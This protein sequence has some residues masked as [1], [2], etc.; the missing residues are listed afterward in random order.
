MK[1]VYLY[2]TLTTMGGADRIIIQK[3]N[4]LAGT[5][6]HKIYIITDSQEGRPVVFPLSPQITHIDT[7]TSFNRQ[8]DL[9]FPLRIFHYGMQMRKYRKAVRTLLSQIKPDI[10]ISTLG[11]DSDFLV[12]LKD[13]SRKIGETHTTRK[14]LRNMQGLLE[15]KGIRRLA[16]LFLKYRIEKT[17]RR[18]DAFIVLNDYEKEAWKEIR[19]AGVIPNSLPFYPAHA[20]DLKPARALCVSRLEQEKGVD[21]LIEVWQL[22]SRKHP[23]WQ[24]DIIG[25]GTQREYLQHLLTEKEM[26][27]CIRL[28]PATQDIGKHYLHSSM[29]LLASRFEGFP[30]VVLEAM[31]Y[32]LPCVCY[33]CPYGPRSIIDNGK[34]GFLVKEGDKEA[35]AD[36]ICRLIEHETLRKDMGENARRDIRKYSQ[37]SVMRQWEN[38]FESVIR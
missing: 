14:N 32:G 33:D 35:M 8:Y 38:L 9:P 22:V 25:E 24:L 34:N 16:G 20:S 27:A 13:G 17:I 6:K 15:Q 21:R 28:Q 37:E 36:K 26:D 1:I 5:N 11:R 12:K 10:V 29:L 4:Y 7:G 18:L 2:T 31:A 30:M 19:E 23:G 3:A